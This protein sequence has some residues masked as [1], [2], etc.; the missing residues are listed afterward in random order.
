MSAHRLSAC[1]AARQLAQRSLRA[2]DLVRD[3]LERIDAREPQV[4]PLIRAPTKACC[5]AC[6]WASKT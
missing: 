5:T 6:P 4:Q 1:E 2:E 3:C